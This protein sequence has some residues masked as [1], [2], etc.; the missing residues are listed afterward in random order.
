MKKIWA[1]FILLLA[2][3]ISYAPA[4]RN[5]FVWDDTALILRDPLIRSWRLISA[6]FNHFL[7]IDATPSDFYRPL[8]RLTYTVDYSV[9]G[10]QPAFYH[11]T[12]IVWHVI[13]A[14]GLLLFAEELLVSF[15]VERRRARTVSLIAALVWAIHPVQNAAVVYISGRADPLAAA[16]GFFG[17]FFLLR[18]KEATR[19]RKLGLFVVTGLLFLLSALS[20][21]AGL[22]FPVIGVV[23]FL[24]RKDWRDL[25]KPGAITALVCATYFVL[26]FGA[27][28]SS[29]PQLTPP[30]PLLVRPIIIARAVA[31]YAGLIVFPWNLHMDRDVETQPTGFSDAS[32]AHAAWRE[33]QTLLGLILIAAYFFWLWRARNRSP[34]GFACLLCVLISY[35]PV[36]GIVALNATVAEHWIYLPSAFLF[37]AI[38]LELAPLAQR[39]RSQRTILAVSAAVLWLWVAFLGCRTFVRTFDWKDSHTFFEQTIAHGGDS[40]RMLINLAGLELSEGKLPEAAA[41]LHTALQKKPDQ[42][43]AIINLASVALKQNNFKQARELLNRATQMPIVD[44]QAHQLLAVLEHKESGKVD[45]LRMRL[46]SRTGP[47]NWNIEKAYI[48]LLDQTGARSAAI[49]EVL[50]CLQTQSYRADSWKLLSELETKAGHADQAANAL[51]QAREYDVHLGAAM[52]GN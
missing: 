38:A 15:A 11:A 45:L 26:R 48:Q 10:F 1:V 30:P 8:Q 46:A 22:I 32:L 17:L 7:F 23:L 28:H 5:G 31:E 50:A 43:L 51:A 36:S 9:A 27:E 49:N 33:L 16:F 12:S 42:P 39:L 24:L 4:V 29:P 21:E 18:A 6:G 47:P 37:L 34:A 25:W 13:A 14:I 20:K 41:H 35:L 44:A 19:G 3:F 40:A 52:S 2:V